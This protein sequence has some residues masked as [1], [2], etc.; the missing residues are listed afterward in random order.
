MMP[1]MPYSYLSM[2]SRSR[3]YDKPGYT[4]DPIR[5]DYQ[6]PK[7]SF[8]S[9]MSNFFLP[10]R[11]GGV[12]VD[13]ESAR[14]A[15]GNS[16]IA[17]GS[18][19]LE[20][21]STGNFIGGLSKGVQGFAGTMRGTLDEERKIRLQM[22]EAQRQRDAEIRAQEAHTLNQEKGT[23]ELE[24][25][26]LER[27]RKIEEYG[28]I[29]NAARGMITEMRQVAA[30]YPKDQTVQRILAVA[31][32]NY[33]GQYSDLA[34]L[35]ELHKLVVSESVEEQEAEQTRGLK[36]LE[37]EALENA[38]SS[39]RDF[40]LRERGVKVSEGYLGLE[41]DK[42]TTG[43]LTPNQIR[44]D[45]EQR[46]NSLLAMTKNEMEKYT[47]PTLA[48][49]ED[50]LL[51]A[52]EIAWKGLRQE[53]MM[54]GIVLPETLPPEFGGRGG[55]APPPVL[56]ITDP[57][58]AT[59]APPSVEPPP[60]PTPSKADD[61]PVYRTILSPGPREAASP[62][63]PNR[64]ELASMVTIEQ[65]LGRSLSEDEGQDALEILREGG[66]ISDVMRLLGGQG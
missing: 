48:Q 53:Y 51:K 22:E 64:R 5:P 60:I 15:R 12:D 20:G 57:V 19:L 36:V 23:E 29:E 16:L 55:I 31:E 17:L 42:K 39:M 35:M 34:K 3:E 10:T 41:R 6:E 26:K 7:P 56:D 45:L 52:R 62:L 38:P 33:R 65:S 40:R 58:P 63:P 14:Q 4:L 47:P 8:G 44:T 11:F 13:E 18:G 27:Q 54:Q 37:Q 66:T 43:G 61:S 32:K 21:A 30:E 2:L 9:R 25:Y 59:V 46:T 49:S 1:F 24:E 50:R 28:S